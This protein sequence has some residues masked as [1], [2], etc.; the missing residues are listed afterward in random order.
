MMILLF[1]LTVSV[2]NM[3]YDMTSL[4]TIINKQRIKNGND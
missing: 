2:N 1:I 4:K 3:R